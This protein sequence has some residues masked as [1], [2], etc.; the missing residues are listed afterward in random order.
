MGVEDA[1]RYLAAKVL[2]GDALAL[3]VLWEYYMRDES[4]STIAA[5][6]RVD[7]TKLRGYIQRV[8]VKAGSHRAAR[9]AVEASYDILSGMPPLI[10]K[11]GGA[12]YCTGCQ[13]SIGTRPM[14]HV[15]TQHKQTLA[16]IVSMAVLKLRGPK[17]AGSVAEKRATGPDVAP[18]PS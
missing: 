14:Y 9:A 15:V 6:Y 10:L 4:P 13:R 8:V 16:S 7:A 3:A 5:K 12:F 18:D 11:H 2:S 17:G 1:V